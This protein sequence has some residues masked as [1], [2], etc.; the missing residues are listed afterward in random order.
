MKFYDTQLQ[1]FVIAGVHG[2]KQEVD[3]VKIST[4][5]GVD[6]DG[7]DVIHDKSYPRGYKY[8]DI[9]PHWLQIEDNDPRFGVH[10][11]MTLVYS[12]GD[13]DDE[14]DY[15]DL[16]LVEVPPL[17]PEQMATKAW[18]AI[19]A[20]RGIDINK[21]KVDVF[22]ADEGVTLTFDGDELSQDRMLRAALLSTGEE[23]TQWKL[24]NNAWAQVTGETLR[25]AARLAGLEQLRIMT[26][27]EE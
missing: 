25:E 16:V 24:A 21:I 2:G 27:A 1:S 9:P 11:G 26:E 20:Q 8:T 6:E 17:T 15:G 18:K 10:P 13:P 7:I 3:Y 19:K 23:T 14:D 22:V 12:P 4:K 5:V